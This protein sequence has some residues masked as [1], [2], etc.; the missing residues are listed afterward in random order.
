MLV[1][2]GGWVSA[3]IA[4]PVGERDRA[5]GLRPTAHS[6]HSDRI[7]LVRSS[8]RQHPLRWCGSVQVGSCRYEEIVAIR[9]AEAQ[10]QRPLGQGKD[11][12]KLGGVDLHRRPCRSPSPALNVH[13]EAVSPMIVV[14][15]NEGAGGAAGTV[16]YRTLQ[17]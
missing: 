1:R 11:G 14:E 16:A 4:A 9:A 10:V 13:P 15:L 2:E 3:L 12:E 7:R 8:S 17:S 5:R 6:E